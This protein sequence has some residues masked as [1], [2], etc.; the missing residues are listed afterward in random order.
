M[1]PAETPSGDATPGGQVATS[2]LQRALP[3]GLVCHERRASPRP[4]LTPRRQP[5][6]VPAAEAKE[7]AAAAA[8][9]RPGV[10]ATRA[11]EEEPSLAAEE[12]SAQGGEAAQ[13]QPEQDG[14]CAG[15][16]PGGMVAMPAA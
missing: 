13:M 2:S 6:P 1:P 15:Q 7:N 4:Q 12:G 11:D 14:G 16:E 8:R 5:R 3:A 10:Q 9:I